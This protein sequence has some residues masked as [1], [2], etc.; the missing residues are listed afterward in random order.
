MDI[1]P[2]RP[3]DAAALTTIHNTVFPADTRTTNTFDKTMNRLLAAGGYALVTSE[4][5]EI[6][7]WIFIFHFYYLSLILR[8]FCLNNIMKKC[9]TNPIKMMILEK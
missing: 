9:I 5:E 4:K 8:F 1:R 2:Y 7:G 6:L 3:A